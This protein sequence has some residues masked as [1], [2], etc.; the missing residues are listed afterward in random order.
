MR[1]LHPDGAR[2]NSQLGDPPCD[3]VR[4]RVRRANRCKADK[5]MFE[6]RQFPQRR[7]AVDFV[8]MRARAPATY[9]RF[10]SSDTR[11]NALL[12]D[13]HHPSASLRA[14]G[15]GHPSDSLQL[16]VV[17]TNDTGSPEFLP[18]NLRNEAPH[19]RPVARRKGRGSPRLARPD[20]HRWTN[21]RDPRPSRGVAH[22]QRQRDRTDVGR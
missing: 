8:C 12:H 7:R 2:M 11:L 16:L 9:S 4:A 14:R 21:T 10:G 13:R 3:R 18:K 20:G 17:T 5:R 22:G 15:W 1:L 6:Q 19:R